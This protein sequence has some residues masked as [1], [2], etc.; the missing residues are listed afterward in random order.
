MKTLVDHYLKH[1]IT[2]NVA[3][4]SIISIFQILNYD[5]IVYAYFTYAAQ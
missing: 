2:V 1:C 4:I 5:S 3:L